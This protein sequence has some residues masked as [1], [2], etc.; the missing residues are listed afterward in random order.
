MPEPEMSLEEW[1]ARIMGPLPDMSE[2]VAVA[3]RLTEANAEKRAALVR[4][5]G[6]PEAV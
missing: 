5:W 1:K 4:E 6:D 2:T 3:K